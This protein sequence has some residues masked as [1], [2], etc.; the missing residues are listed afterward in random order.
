MD[1]QV[2]KTQIYYD[3]I[4][5]GYKELYHEEQIQKINLVKNYFRKF[6]KVLD[7]GCGDGVLNQFIS[8]DINL[9]SFDLSFNLL[10]LNSNKNKIQGNITNLPFKKESFDLVFAFTVI[11]DLPIEKIEKSILEIK[12]IL[13]KEGIFIISFLKISLKLDLIINSLKNNFEVIELKEE[14]KDFIYILKK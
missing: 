7:L 1:N 6:G 3:G 9:I 4:S 5:K 8:N 11:Q 2:K 12:K 10:K 13:K 14:E